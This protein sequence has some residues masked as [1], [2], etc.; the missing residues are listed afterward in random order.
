MIYTLVYEYNGGGKKGESGNE[1][2][3]S[4]KLVQ[5]IYVGIFRVFEKQKDLQVTP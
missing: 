2:P 5:I 1:I 3:L 4:K